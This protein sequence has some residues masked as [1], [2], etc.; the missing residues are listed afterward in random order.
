ME[1]VTDRPLREFVYLDEVSL[2]SLLSS[3]TG[4]VTDTLSEQRGEGLQVGIDGTAGYSI[5]V[6]SK[7][8][9]TSRYQTSN[10]SS[11]QTSRKATVQSWFGELHAR[12]GL[13]LI[14]MGHLPEQVTSAE[15]LVSIENRSIL[16]PA[17]ELTRGALVEFKVRLSADPVFHLGTMVSEFSSIVEESPEM[18]AGNEIS[19]QLKEFQPVNKALQ[20]M[21]AGLIPI[22]CDALEYV[23]IEI[24]NIEYIVQKESL[25]GI[26]IAQRPLQIVGVTEHV[27]YW[28]DLRRVLFSDVE[29]TILGRIS[30]TGIQNSWNAIKLGDLFR[31]IAPDWDEKINIAS[32]APFT[33]NTGGV[34]VKINEIQ[35]GEALRHYRDEFLQLSNQSLSSDQEG[36]LDDE[37][38]RLQSRTMTVSDQ[39]SAFHVVHDF[40]TAQLGQLV[41]LS[42]ASDMRANARQKSGLSLFPAQSADTVTIGGTQPP[43]DELEARLLDIEVVAIYW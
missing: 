39:R 22:R 14:E 1:A 2:R 24:D 19:R 34:T 16:A 33:G 36:E 13:R 8:E 6:L 11:L 7:A 4:E 35:L 37:I 30:R 17:P 40:L 21:L 38:I 20:R 41:D 31:A 27:A 3:Q 12:S 29:F 26:E 43:N 42:A 15:D 5:P 9:L 10:S 25:S 28:K 32:L 23:V 18:F